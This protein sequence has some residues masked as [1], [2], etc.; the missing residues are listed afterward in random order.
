MTQTTMRARTGTWFVELILVNQREKGI[1]PSRA[2]DQMTRPAVACVATDATPAVKLDKATVRTIAPAVL[3]VACSSTYKIGKL[4][5]GQKITVR[6][7][8][9]SGPAVAAGTEQDT[10]LRCDRINILDGEEERE[11]E[12]QSGRDREQDG[13]KHGP[14]R[15]EGRVRQL[16]AEMGDTVVAHD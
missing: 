9:P 16:F 15:I 8:M 5:R 13:A 4:W 6:Q 7:Q 2:N 10:Q 11:D 3:P 12:E 14:R 1:P